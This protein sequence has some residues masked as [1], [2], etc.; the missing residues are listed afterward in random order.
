MYTSDLRQNICWTDVMFLIG[1]KNDRNVLYYIPLRA[2][3]DT[4]VVRRR[5]VLSSVIKKKK[6]MHIPYLPMAR[7]MVIRYSR[8]L[9]RSKLSSSLSS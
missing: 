7:Y 1:F 2:L 9:S 8:Q 3:E 6:K 4:T 5:P